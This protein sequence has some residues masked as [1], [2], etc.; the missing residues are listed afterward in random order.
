VRGVL[1]EGIDS[2]R[3]FSL[4]WVTGARRW[5]V[6]WLWR[7]RGWAHRGRRRR[8]NLPGGRGGQEG[9]EVC[10]DQIAGRKLGW[11]LCCLPTGR[12]L[13]FVLRMEACRLEG[14]GCSSGL[15]VLRAADE[16]FFFRAS[17]SDRRRRRLYRRLW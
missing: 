8:G 3:S 9:G 16:G 11:L 14:P 13:A 12:D 7:G 15:R 17:P 2:V 5:R 4:G 6:R 1:A 10:V